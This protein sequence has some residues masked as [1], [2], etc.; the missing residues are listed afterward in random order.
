MSTQLKLNLAYFVRAM[1]A[2][3]RELRLGQTAASLS[4]ISLLAMV[5]LLTLAFATLA[6]FPI[7]SKIL[8]AVQLLVVQNLLPD[9]FA[10]MIYRYINQFIAKARTLSLIGIG[11]LL[12]TATIMMLTLDR[13]LNLIWRVRKPRPLLHRISIYWMALILGPILVGAGASL[14]IVLAGGK[15]GMS[16]GF[17]GVEWWDL[18]NL[19]LTVAA[20][21][22]CYRWIPNV[23]VRW[24]D[25]LMGALA[26]AVLSEI[27]REV[28]LGYFTAVPTYQQVYGPLAAIPA[29]LIWTYLTWWVFLAGAL[30]ASILPSWRAVSARISVSKKTTGDKT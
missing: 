24:R 14:A 27:A 15:R 8:E 6:S 25:A 7:F 17:L 4:F 19:G 11:F 10:T 13:T 29:L 5:P 12:V 23:E 28:F 30:L 2:R 9:G 18:V 16:S 21:A 1:A 20:F 3:E 26:G 22:L